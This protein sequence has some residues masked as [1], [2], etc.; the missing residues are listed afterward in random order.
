MI[1]AGADP[2]AEGAIALLDAETRRVLAILDMPMAGPELLVRE[3]VGDLDGAL[4]GRRVGHLIMEKQAPFA[5]EGRQAGATSAFNMGQRFMALK[6]IAA[7]YG[8]PVEI[9]TAQKWQKHF[10]IAKADKAKSIALADQLMPQDCGLWKVRRGY[11]TKAHSF[12]RAEASLI[13]L[14]GVRMFTGI[15]SPVP[16][17]ANTIRDLPDDTLDDM[18]DEAANA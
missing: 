16:P 8:W 11:C 5:K 10:G 3:L 12:G 14:Y 7:C 13:A 2:G 4:D 6:A 9:V 17:L 1:I 18:I 15:A